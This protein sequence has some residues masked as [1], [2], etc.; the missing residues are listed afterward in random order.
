MNRN[1][2][3]VLAV[4]FLMAGLT[5]I[6]QAKAQVPLQEAPLIQDDPFVKSCRLTPT[7]AQELSYPGRD[8]VTL[9]NNL[10][11]PEGKAVPAAGE[12]LYVTGRIV[13]ENCVPVLGATVDLWQAN[14]SGIYQFATEGELLNAEP[15]FAGSGRT[16]TDNLG[17]YG[18]ITLVPSGYGKRAP[19]LNFKVSHPDYTTSNYALFFEGVAANESDPVLRSVRSDSRY[20]LVSKMYDAGD[21]VSRITF[22][23]T[24][25]GTSRYRSF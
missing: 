5:G 24:L 14:P 11:Q 20:R 9:S 7:V 3:A 15:L 2:F 16:T 22:D 4:T 10:A 25:R 23:M 18:F 12:I 17:R 1:S 8:R 6:P 13:D 19:H 21:G